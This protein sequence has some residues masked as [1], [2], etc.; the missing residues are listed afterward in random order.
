MY[1]ALF[2]MAINLI[3]FFTL[4]VIIPKFVSPTKTSHSLNT[5]ALSDVF[6]LLAKY[7][8]KSYSSDYPPVRTV[9]LEWV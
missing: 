9:H 5:S 8:N 7:A 6:Q 2:C 4:V 1:I 3:Y